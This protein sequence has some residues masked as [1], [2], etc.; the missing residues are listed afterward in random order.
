MTPPFFQARAQFLRANRQR[1]TD[2]GEAN[3]HRIT[4]ARLDGFH[5][6]F[7]L[8]LLSPRIAVDF[9]K[10][11]PS[12]I[13]QSKCRTMIFVI[14]GYVARHMAKCGFAPNQG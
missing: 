14:N 10:E 7:V 5:D 12:G 13:R 2:W 8:I 3:N 1:F 4:G 6:L 11:A 9:E